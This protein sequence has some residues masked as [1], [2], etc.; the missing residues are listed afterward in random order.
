MKKLLLLAAMLAFTSCYAQVPPDTDGG[1]SVS[2]FLAESDTSTVVCPAEFSGVMPSYILGVTCAH[3]ERTTSQFVNEVDLYVK[4]G[5]QVS[6][7]ENMGLG[8]I[9]SSFEFAD[10]DVLLVSFTENLISERVGLALFVLA[11][12]P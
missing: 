6:A 8:E 5:V 9:R 7:W 10:G 4:N 2:N 1:A 11:R 12:E 3:Y